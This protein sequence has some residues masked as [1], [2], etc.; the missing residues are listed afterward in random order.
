MI[1]VTGGAGF[2]GSALIAGL[3]RRDITD[4]LVVD[5]LGT[6]EKWKNLRSLAFA[7]YAEKADLPNMVAEGRL[8]GSVE[9]VFHL[10]ACSDTTETDAAL[11]P[12]AT[13]KP[14]SKTMRIALRTC[15]LST[16]MAAPSTCSTCGRAGKGFS[17]R[18]SG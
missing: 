3:N 8:D 18:L 15:A 4:I 5:E 12:T 10:G 11:R 7:D 9:A 17:A 1:L 2:I 14:D 6:D 16:C 13:A